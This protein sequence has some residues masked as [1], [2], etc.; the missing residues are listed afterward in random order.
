MRKAINHVI[1]LAAFH[2]Y[3]VVRPSPDAMALNIDTHANFAKEKF[4]FFGSL[5]IS[6]P[7]RRHFDEV[8]KRLDLVRRES[9]CIY[10]TPV[11]SLGVTLEPSKA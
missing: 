4:V 1:T 11:S 5:S 2:K 9:R 7:A 8:S 6:S 3:S 10:G